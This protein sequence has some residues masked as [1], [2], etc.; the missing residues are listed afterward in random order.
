MARVGEDVPHGAEDEGHCISVIPVHPARGL[1]AARRR[2]PHALYDHVDR[3]I[4][5]YG[6]SV[7]K[8]RLEREGNIMRKHS[9]NLRFCVALR[10]GKGIRSVVL[11]L[12]AMV[13]D[14][15]GVHEHARKTMLGTCLGTLRKRR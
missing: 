7:V 4:T 5:P 11:P 15:R 12:R 10:Y 6:R 3:A 13:G 1:R 2:E 14:T 9:K 8:S